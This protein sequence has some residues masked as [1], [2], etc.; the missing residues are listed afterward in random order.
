MK[1]FIPLTFGLILSLSA[2]SSNTISQKGSPAPTKA[3]IQDKMETLFAKRDSFVEK[4]N[5][6]RHLQVHH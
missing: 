3:E 1:L 2:L 6:L 4:G 5:Y